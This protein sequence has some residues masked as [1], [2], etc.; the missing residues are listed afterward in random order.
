MSAEALFQLAQPFA[1]IHTTVE[2][3]VGLV[4]ILNKPSFIDRLVDEWLN[5][6][7]VIPPLN[8][9]QIQAVN[10][11]INEQA[12][13]D[14]KVTLSYSENASQIHQ[15]ANDLLTW[16]QVDGVGY[17]AIDAMLGFGD[18]DDNGDELRSLELALD[19][20]MTDLRDVQ[21]LIVDVR[22]NGGGKDF[23]S[24]AIASRFATNETHAYSKQARLGSGRSELIDVYIQPRGAVQYLGPVYLLTSNETASAAEV[25]TLAMREF[26]QVT[27]IGEAT[28]GGLSDQLSKK[29]FNGWNASVGNEYYL[30]TDGSWYEGVGIPVDVEVAQFSRQ[31]RQ[32]EIDF[33]IE[34]VIELLSN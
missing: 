4:K 32:S 19:Q 22:R 30:A 15:A 20:A 17:L 3:S 1:D 9:A 13:I 2:T 5:L 18:I 14:R 34:A 11:Y 27:I 29:L 25:F 24:L 12:Y 26:P 33:G 8:D 10:T 7:G 28:Q 6:E 23:L 31:A 16:Y 21:A